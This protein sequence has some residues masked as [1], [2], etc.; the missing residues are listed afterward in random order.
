MK[1]AVS[2][3]SYGFILSAAA[4]V[5]FFSRKFGIKPFCYR[6]LDTKKPLYYG[7]DHPATYLKTDLNE[8]ACVLNNCDAMSGEA[9][10]LS[11]E[12]KGDLPFDLCF[13][14]RRKEDLSYRIYEF[15]RNDPDLIDTI[16]QLGK[17][18]SANG[19]HIE[20]QDIPD[21]TY[22]HIEEDDGYETVWY[23]TS[24]IV[25]AIIGQEGNR[26]EDSLQ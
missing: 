5:M 26:N 14:N 11:M 8:M 15:S 21:K 3:S 9:C 18:A 4:N 13:E 24:P 23:S 7:E 19:S 12:D 6:R 20:I 22:W 17:A 10:F 16:R 1:I 2:R 25:R